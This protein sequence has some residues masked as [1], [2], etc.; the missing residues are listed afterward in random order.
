MLSM[1]ISN[2]NKTFHDEKDSRTS[3]K[4]AFSNTDIEKDDSIEE[5]T[6]IKHGDA[7]SNN[8]NGTIDNI[9]TF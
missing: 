3:N 8:L 9:A 7:N 4:E 2:N 6:N 1:N 5:L